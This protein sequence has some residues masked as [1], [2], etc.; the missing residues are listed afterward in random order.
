MQI[1]GITPQPIKDA[2]DVTPSKKQEESKLKDACQ[3]FESLFLSQILKEMKKSIP[4]AEGEEGKD[5]DMYEDL[6]YEEI[7]K[8]MAASGGIGMANILYQ[9]MKDI[10]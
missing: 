8:S 10:M 6:M 7:S 3:Q 9:Q 5:K 2:A 4:K 1:E